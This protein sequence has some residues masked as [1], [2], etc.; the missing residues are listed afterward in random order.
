[1]RRLLC[2][3]LRRHARLVGYW[4]R[5]CLFAAI[6]TP[7][8]I[9]GAITERAVQFRNSVLGDLDGSG[10]CARCPLGVGQRWLARR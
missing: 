3:E 10:V 9:I 7:A 4:I 1:M 8:L 5:P 2:D 6:I